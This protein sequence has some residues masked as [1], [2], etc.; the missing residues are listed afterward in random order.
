MYIQGNKCFECS[1]VSNRVWQWYMY[2][3]NITPP[4]RLISS[5]PNTKPCWRSYFS[6][7]QQ[8]QINKRHGQTIAMPGSL[9]QVCDLFKKAAK[10]VEP[11]KKED[12][13]QVKLKL[14][15]LL[16]HIRQFG[17]IIHIHLLPHNS[18]ILN[19]IIFCLTALQLLYF[20]WWNRKSHIL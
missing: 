6:K 13:I 12:H 20:G 5:K 11:G 10:T 17:C 4:P 2:M 15:L 9:C 1:C 18:A 19:I 8:A 16:Q 14:V 3:S 7:V